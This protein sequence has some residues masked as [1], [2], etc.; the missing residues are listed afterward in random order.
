[1]AAVASG[2]Q[3]AEHRW[4]RLQRAGWFDRTHQAPRTDQGYRRTT[5]ARPRI[6]RHVAVRGGLAQASRNGFRFL[7]YGSRLSLP[8]PLV[9]P[10]SLWENASPQKADLGSRGTRIS[11]SPLPAANG[12]DGR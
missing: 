4:D 5:L 12:L 1:S 3:L 2:Q 9:Q 11:H 8:L 6:D 7:D 10:R